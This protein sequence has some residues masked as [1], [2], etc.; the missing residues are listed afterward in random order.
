MSLEVNQ[1][2]GGLPEPLGGTGRARKG[3]PPTAYDSCR[4]IVGYYLCGFIRTRH[5][6]SADPTRSDRLRAH[7]HGPSGPKSYRLVSSLSR[8]TSTVSLASASIVALVVVIDHLSL[9]IS[10]IPQYTLKRKRRYRARRQMPG[11]V[12]M[13]VRTD[14]EYGILPGCVLSYQ[15]QSENWLL[16]E[17]IW[18]PSQHPF[19]STNLPLHSSLS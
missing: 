11:V 16:S 5:R 13:I 8:C 4:W 9:E 19:H 14:R 6:E 2:P 17:L 3:I 15:P 7:K 10:L 1:Q 12:R 18:G